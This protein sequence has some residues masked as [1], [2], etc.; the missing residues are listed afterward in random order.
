MERYGKEVQVRARAW[1]YH[2]RPSQFKYD[3]GEYYLNPNLASEGVTNAFIRYQE[4]NYLS[5]RPNFGNIPFG[6]QGESDG[7]ASPMLML[8]VE[9]DEEK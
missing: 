5:Y 9:E 7:I 3:P 1:A 8:F 6:V 4:N 2:T